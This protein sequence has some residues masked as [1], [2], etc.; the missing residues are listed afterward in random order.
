MRTIIDQD[1]YIDGRTFIIIDDIADTAA[2]FYVKASRQALKR[3]KELMPYSSLL[4]TPL[5][6]VYNRGLA[7]SEK[8]SIIPGISL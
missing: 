6:P 7:H 4:A 3:K 8:G 2:T 1:A 5:I